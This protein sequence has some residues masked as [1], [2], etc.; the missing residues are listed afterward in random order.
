MTKEA[1][2]FWAARGMSLRKMVEG[3]F[4]ESA[5]S[6]FGQSPQKAREILGDGQEVIGGSIRRASINFNSADRS[7]VIW[8]GDDTHHPEGLSVRLG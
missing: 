2:R 6:C 3:R 1:E 7:A 8:I 4:I 5:L